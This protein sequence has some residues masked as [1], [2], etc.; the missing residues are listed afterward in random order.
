[1]W[2]KV[3]GVGTIVLFVAW[4]G[5]VLQAWSTGGIFLRLISV[6]FLIGTAVA[7]R[8]GFRVLT[9]GSHDN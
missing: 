5:F 9:E 3:L 1:M 2:I 6:A 7:A 4:I 8:W